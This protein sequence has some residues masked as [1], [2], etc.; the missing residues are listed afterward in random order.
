MSF[1]R[2]PYFV[3]VDNVETVSLEDISLGKASNKLVKT[4]SDG[5]IPIGIIP[6]EIATKI[7]KINDMSNNI[8]IQGQ[9]LIRVSSS[10][11]G[12]DGV[13]TIS[14]VSPTFYPIVAGSFAKFVEVNFK[15]PA[16]FPILSANLSTITYSDILVHV[17]AKIEP[18]SSL[19]FTPFIE[20]GT[21][22]YEI[23]DISSEF[24]SISHIFSSIEPSASHRVVFGVKSYTQDEVIVACRN[25]SIS[26]TAL[27]RVY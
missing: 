26:V 9:G 15:N 1:H 25:I 2:K 12:E 16:K 24:V 8:K 17:T 11:S 5:K 7:H 20:I 22:Q 27:P 6:E 18:S 3:K 4:G 21:N 19:T 23:P 10:K 14:S 13:I